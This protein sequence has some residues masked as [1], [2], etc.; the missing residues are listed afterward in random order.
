MHTVATGWSH[1][2]ISRIR[3]CGN[4]PTSGAHDVLIGIG[5][6]I[7][8]FIAVRWAIVL[9]A[10]GREDVATGTSATRWRSER[11]GGIRRCPPSGGDEFRV[12]SPGPDDLAVQRDNPIRNGRHARF[13]VAHRGAG[14]APSRQ[15]PA[16]FAR[17]VGMGEVH[18]DGSGSSAA[19]SWRPA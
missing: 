1:A 18:L 5:G 9:F 13:A 12:A 16:G 8:V 10:A 19:P 6:F 2:L 17:A 3:V 14:G 15:G 4:R 7:G 11:G